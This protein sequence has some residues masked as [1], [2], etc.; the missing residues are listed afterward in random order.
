MLK[1]TDDFPI[2]PDHYYVID[3]RDFLNPKVLPL[4][5]VNRK[6]AYRAI[7]MNVP[8]WKRKRFSVKKGKS[9][10]T[11]KINY[12]LKRA[13][14]RY[15]VKYQYPD[16][17]K[18]F[19]QKKTYRTVIRRRLRRMGL[20]NIIKI[21]IHIKG[22]IRNKGYVPNTQKIANTP[23]T[24]AKA[25]RLERKPDKYIYFLLKKKLSR[26]PNKLFRIKVI[27]V[28]SR[29]GQMKEFWMSTFKNDVIHPLMM[30]ET[31][32]ILNQIKWNKTKIINEIYR[33]FYLR[34]PKGEPE[35]IL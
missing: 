20:L 26:N 13:T 9:I 1:N 33:K 22:E 8:L 18:T 10:L 17:K 3:F 31:V 6:A 29:R 19:Q 27:R 11:E 24:S 32:P 7:E 16:C 23:N 35:T 25:F 5:Y 30:A 28:D 4:F 14:L 34:I 2:K 12:T 21:R 15:F